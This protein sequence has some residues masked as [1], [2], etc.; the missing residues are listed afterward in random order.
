[1]SPSGA[2]TC[3]TPGLAE[4]GSQSKDHWADPKSLSPTLWA[5]MS[6]RLLRIALE[7]GEGRGIQPSDEYDA[8]HYSAAAVYADVLVTE[9][10]GFSKICEKL[11]GTDLE[12]IGLLELHAR[13]EAMFKRAGIRPRPVEEKVHDSEH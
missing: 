5:Y 8:R 11:E 7:V 1:M 13:V 9:D 10:R 6:Y 2:E 4:S 12:I 3:S